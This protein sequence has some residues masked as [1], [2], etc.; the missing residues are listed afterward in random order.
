MDIGNKDGKSPMS[1]LGE[2]E[3]VHLS[4]IDRA[5]GSRTRRSSVPSDQP[6][7]GDAVQ[8]N[9]AVR[10][11]SETAHDLRSPLTTVREA[12]RLVH[13]GDLGQVTVEQSELLKTAIDQCD[14]IEQ[15]VGEMM[16]MERLRTGAPRASRR[17]IT[18]DEIR[19][20]IDQTLR[21]WAIPRQIDVLW[22]ADIHSR[23]TAKPTVYADPSMIRRLVVNLVVN[24]IRASVEG[25]EI[26][27]RFAASR[28]G[29]FVRCS[30]IDQGR[31]IDPEDLKRIAEH[32]VSFSAGEGLGLT[33][34]RQLAAVHFSA[35]EI[36]SRR[37]AGTEVSFEL[38]A[39]GPRSVAAAWARWRVVMKRLSSDSISRPLVRPRRRDGIPGQSIS[40]TPDSAQTI[41]LDSPAENQRSV[42]VELHHRDTK[43]RVSSCFAAGVVTLGAAVSRQAADQFGEVL[44]RELQMFDIS[45]RVETRQWVWVFDADQ[46][47]V[48]QRI[49]SIDHAT[50]V[51]L[52]GVR[53]TWSEPQ[54]IPVDLKSSATRLSDLMVR[55]ALFASTID[56]GLVHDEV[57]LGTAPISPSDS[58][59]Q[60]LDA[61]LRRLSHQ[62]RK[63]T[64]RLKQQ[65]LSLRPNV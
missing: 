58:A 7:R 8:L 62:M 56:H 20:T 40:S 11:M 13:D 24:A 34:C 47:S 49:E 41:R 1:T 26:L 31:G 17:W 63:Q 65:S 9:G 30:V 50:R 22:D 18:I 28:G 38:P 39:A 59:V 29:N 54:I 27:I 14:C 61:E 60:R 4:Q 42:V 51:G 19:A 12:I 43:P 48:V 5:K 21:P 45:Y 53:S 64:Q 32:H 35:L 16:Q 57:R 46:D 36:R 52:D 10:L 6:V 15:M 23:G 2:S 44:D 37:G 25:Q 3:S 33:I 55:Q